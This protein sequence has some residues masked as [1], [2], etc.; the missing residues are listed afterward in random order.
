MARPHA[1][2]ALLRKVV[3]AVFELVARHGV[4]GASMRVVAGRTGL[5]TGTLNYHFRNKAGLLEAAL[6]YAYREPLDWAEHSTGARRGLGRLLRRY[7]LRRREVRDWWRF[8]CAVTAQAAK[9]RHIAARQRKNQR[10]LVA[11]FAKV[12][13]SGVESGELRRGLDADREAE[14]LVALAHGVALRQLVDGSNDVI[15]AS[16]ALLASEVR[17]LLTGHRA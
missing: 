8:W 2:A 11:F 4:D 10:A 5:S 17:G 13:A 15:R 9:D 12:I 6:D 14:R 16:E 1:D 7:V 3:V